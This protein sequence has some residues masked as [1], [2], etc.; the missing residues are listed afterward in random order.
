MKKISASDLKNLVESTGSNYFN[1]DSMKF[2]GDTMSNY[3]VRVVVVDKVG[4]TTLDMVYELYRKKPVKR[5]LKDS[6]FFDK[7][8]KKIGGDVKVIEVI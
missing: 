4:W 6:V 3:G 8:G 7:D 2:F 1:K 5:G